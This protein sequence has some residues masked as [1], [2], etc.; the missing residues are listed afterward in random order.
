MGHDDIY[1]YTSMACTRAS[2]RHVIPCNVKT[3]NMV[4]IPFMPAFLKLSN[5]Y[6]GLWEFHYT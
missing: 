5:K 6:C 3:I 2:R 1:S 4:Q